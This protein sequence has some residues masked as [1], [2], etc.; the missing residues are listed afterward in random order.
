MSMF[1]AGTGS[2]MG[3]EHWEKNSMARDRVDVKASCVASTNGAYVMLT[4][5]PVKIQRTQERL[6]APK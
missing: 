1:V 2:Y 3:Q 6:S 4:D 5:L